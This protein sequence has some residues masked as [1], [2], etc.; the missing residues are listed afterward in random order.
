[1]KVNE[2][3]YNVEHKK[4]LLRAIQNDKMHLGNDK[5]QLG[6]LLLR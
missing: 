2:I 6:K 1:M 5:R 3:L 4:N